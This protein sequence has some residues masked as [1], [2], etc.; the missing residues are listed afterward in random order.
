MNQAYVALLRGI[1]VGGANRLPM[2]RL[3]TLF[4]EAGA[5]DVE[6]LIHPIN[7]NLVLA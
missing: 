7:V 5:S 1:N 6:T 2:A 4:I 3:R